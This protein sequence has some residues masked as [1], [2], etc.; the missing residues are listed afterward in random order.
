MTTQQA[1]A[2]ALQ[3]HQAGRLARAEALYHQIL[4]VQPDHAEAMHFLGVIAARAGNR[5]LAADWIRKSIALRPNNPAAHSNLGKVLTEQGQFDE[6]LAAYRR[7]LQL[8]PDLPEAQVNLGNA[9][10]E[11]GQFDEAVAAYQHALLVQPDFSAAHYNLANALAE[12]GQL[13]AAVAAYR[14]ALQLRPGQPEAHLNLGNALRELGQLEGAVAE[15]R[16]ALQLRPSYAGACHNLGDALREQGRLDDALAAFRRALE[17]KPDDPDAHNNI[18]TTLK[19]R[20]ELDEAAAA[21]RRA[22]ALRPDHAAAHSNLLYALHFHPAH[23]E[24]SI[25]AEQQSWNRRFAEP[26]QPLIAP[27]AHDRDPRRRLRIGYLSPD[28]RGHVVGRNLL[29]LFQHHDHLNFEIFCYS[30]VA[31]PDRQTEEFRRHADHWRSTVGMADEALAAM[32][33]QDAVDILVDLSQHMAGNRLAVFARQPAP[34]QVSFAGY[35]AGT[36][37]EAIP[38]RIS[39]RHLE[40]EIGDGRS[41]FGTE[42]RAQNPEL[43]SPN[44]DLRTEQVLLLDSFWCYDPCGA[45][46]AVNALP[47]QN[48]GRVIFGSLNNFCKIN[49]PVLKLWARVL[50]EVADSRLLLLSGSGSHRLRFRKVLE[51]AGIDGA[52]LDF[53]EPRGRTAYLEL[54]HGL[55]IVLDPFP[56]HGH[57]TSLDALW[58]GVPVVSLT[59][60]QAVSRAGF[61][62]WSNLGA[63]GFA[64]FSENDYVRIATGLAHD[65]PRLATLRATLRSRMQASPLMDAP[66]FARGIEAAFRTMWQQRC[67]ANP[68][69]SP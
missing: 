66:R 35:P 20:G 65:L 59:G 28:L 26:L 8:N 7:A 55:D 6:A 69:A 36:G 14:R 57:T 54:Y 31:H 37:L 68:S 32:I 27:H 9:L 39:D 64:A 13:D 15:F 62:Q 5:E 41:E 34:V 30:G 11:R 23:N 63:P 1:F 48:S 61:S 29:P 16:R 38:Y 46:L 21:F 3:H 2:L 18:G 25:A 60:N 22:L 42:L 19:D 43:R 17:L 40:S 52:R 51:Q 33:R 67:V 4:A 58:M 44:S 56:Y 47:A 50:G 10:R 24:R 12:R 49:E 53:A 45:D